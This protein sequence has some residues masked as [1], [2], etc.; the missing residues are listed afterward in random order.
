MTIV[1]LN[2]FLLGFYLYLTWLLESTLFVCHWIWFYFSVY[3]YLWYSTWYSTHFFKLHTCLFIWHLV[4]V[5]TIFCTFFCFCSYSHKSVHTND[6]ICCRLFFFLLLCCLSLW[7]YIAL[8][9]LGQLYL[10]LLIWY[11]LMYV[12]II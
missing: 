7:P 3:M 1:D 10:V 2:I 12:T 4:F 8:L 5:H 9:H 6:S 11:D